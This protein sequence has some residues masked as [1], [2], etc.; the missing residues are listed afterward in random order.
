MFL[1]MRFMG[2]GHAGANTF[3]GIMDLPPPVTQKSYDKIAS[4]IHAV[5][6]IVAEKKYAKCSGSRI[7]QVHQIEL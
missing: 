4:H 2:K 1:A 6:H 3:C 5:T 7:R